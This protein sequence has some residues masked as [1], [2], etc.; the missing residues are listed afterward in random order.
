MAD[1]DPKDTEA[2][3][4]QQAEALRQLIE[5]AQ[6]IHRETHQHLKRLRHVGDAPKKR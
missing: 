6:Q 1:A 2:I 4:K 5:E 3:L